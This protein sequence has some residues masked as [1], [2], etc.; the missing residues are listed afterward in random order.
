[1]GLQRLLARTSIITIPFLSWKASPGI[2]KEETVVLSA[3]CHSE[4]C[5]GVVG[6]QPQLLMHEPG[7]RV[8]HRQ[9]PYRT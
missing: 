5:E 1:M 6:A 3:S 4:I 2:S 8:P 7:S 9:I